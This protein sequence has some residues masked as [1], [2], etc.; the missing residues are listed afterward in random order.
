LSVK[1]DGVSFAMSFICGLSTIATLISPPFV[2]GD[3]PDDEL[4]EPPPQPTTTAATTAHNAAT[5]PGRRVPRMGSLL[6][7]LIAEV[8]FFRTLDDL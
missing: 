4:F 1:S 3:P 5:D 2:A 6:L 8:T 7:L